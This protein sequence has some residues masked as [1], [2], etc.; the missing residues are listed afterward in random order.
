MAIT[1][2]QQ[3]GDNDAHAERSAV[4]PTARAAES[5]L[6][7][8]PISSPEVQ[9]DL[10]SLLVGCVQDYAIFAIDPTGHVRTWNR[11]AERLKGY[12]TSEILGSHFSVFY[13]TEE[14]EQGKP[15]R[16]LEIAVR[17]GRYED[18]GWR[19]RKDGSRF[20]ATVVIT[21]IRDSAGELIGFAKVTRDLSERRAAQQRAIEDARR[22]A[23]SESANR[24]KSTFLA[25]M[26][27]EL[28]TPLNAIAGYAD[29][30]AAGIGGELSEQQRS[31]LERIRNSQQHLLSIINDLLNLSRIEA[32]QLTYE[33]TSVSLNE[34]I[35]SSIPM[36]E[37]QAAARSVRVEY[38]EEC[39]AIAL[40][41]G[42][43]VEQILLNLL[44]NAVKFTPAGGRIVV[45][46]GVD[47]DSMVLKVADTGSGIASEHLDAIFEPFVQVGRSLANPHEGTGLGL[48]ISRDLARGMGGE[49]RAESTIGEGSTFILTLPAA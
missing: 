4:S 30:L 22:V 27:H 15:A 36:V 42:P 32:G 33:A 12:T 23:A 44:S 7:E 5:T 26:S 13:E 41:D 48:A 19:V 45:S 46:C 43:K 6:P 1:A 16:A 29:L 25:A 28:R 9:S 18:E 39:T 21:A 34:A 24:A 35:E 20:W 3:A 31:F 47:G 11:G 37:P 14:R 40:A 10:Y 38:I 2:E 17:D 8:A 49:L